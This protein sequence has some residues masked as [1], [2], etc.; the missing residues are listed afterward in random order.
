MTFSTAAVLFGGIV[1]LVAG[2]EAFVRG[3]SRLAAAIGIS[4]LVIGLTV[5]AFGTSAPEVAVSVQ[6]AFSGAADLALGNVV[7][8][9]IFNILLILGLSAVVAP[10]VVDHQ[11]IRLD[12]PVMVGVSFLL[13]L[14]ALDGSI[15]R[16]DGLLFASGAIGYTSYLVLQSRRAGRALAAEYEGEFSVPLHPRGGHLL[17]AALIVSGLAFLVI[18]SRALVS[19]AVTIA[20]SFGVSELVIGLTIVAAGTSLPEV[21]TSLIATIRGE[22][23]IAVGNVIGSNIFNILL[24]LGVSSII[25]PGGIPVAAAALRFDIPVMLAVAV[26][27]LPIFFSGNRIDRWEGMLFLGYYFAYTAYLVL[28][29]AQHDAL[30]IFSAIMA[31]FVLPLTLVTLLTVMIRSWRDRRKLHPPR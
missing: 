23:D 12:V 24:V 13:L 16:V 28:L 22:R 8:S 2:A 26:A 11:L 27:C 1:L 10:L 5:V 21:A 17:S 7:G 30:P 25:A 19:A 20:Q 29:S 15:S 3:A 31:L 18:G 6:S 9:N 14:L 4:P